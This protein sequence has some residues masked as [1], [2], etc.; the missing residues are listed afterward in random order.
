MV[1]SMP[2]PRMSLSL[3]HLYLN[4]F[5]P[6]PLP[7][8]LGKLLFKSHLNVTPSIHSANLYGVSTMLQLWFVPLTPLLSTLVHTSASRGHLDCFNELMGFQVRQAVSESH[9]V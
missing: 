9:F 1:R 4:C 2:F 5:S 8:L 6:S 7:S 3:P